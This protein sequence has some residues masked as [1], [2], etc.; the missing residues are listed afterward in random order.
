MN[1]TLNVFHLIEQGKE[2]VS[3]PGPV[4]LVGKDLTDLLIAKGILHKKTDSDELKE[5]IGGFLKNTPI[6]VDAF[7]F[8]SN[9]P[10]FMVFELQPRGLRGE[11]PIQ[12][13]T[14]D[15]ELGGL[16]EVTSASARVLCCTEGSF[17]TLRRYAAELSA[18]ETVV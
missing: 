3:V 16:F 12:A 1:E 2:P 14:G 15:K 10:L 4:E 17:E 8:T 9:G 13:L 7:Y 5:S 6:T 18:K 11:E